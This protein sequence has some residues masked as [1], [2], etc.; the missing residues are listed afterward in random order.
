M[1][2][3]KVT[4]SLHWFTPS[5]MPFIGYAASTREKHGISQETAIPVTSIEPEKAED[6]IKSP[7]TAPEREVRELLPMH[8]HPLNGV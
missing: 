4:T 7:A 8:G 5:T 1:A 6:K 2:R 3:I